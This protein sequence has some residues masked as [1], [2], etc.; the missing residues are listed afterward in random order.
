MPT[1]HFLEKFGYVGLVVAVLLPIGES[2]PMWF[3]ALVIAIVAGA[4]LLRG[5]SIRH[6]EILRRGP[7]V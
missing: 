2:W 3:T 7:K 5:Q 6:R 1:L 4:L